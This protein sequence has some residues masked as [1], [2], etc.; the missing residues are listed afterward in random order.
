MNVRHKA[1]LNDQRMLQRQDESASRNL[2][3]GLD[4]I[5]LEHAE[6][7]LIP[8]NDVLAA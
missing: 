6:Q 5:K 8:Y 1:L 4:R 2:N 3:L 7:Q